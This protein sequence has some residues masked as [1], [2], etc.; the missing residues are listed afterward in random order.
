MLPVAGAPFVEHIVHFL[1]KQGI[2]RFVFLTGYLANTIEH[3]FTSSRFPGLDIDFV[4]EE[5]PLGT[6][7]AVVHAL[8]S[9]AISGLFFLLNGDSFTP[10]AYDRLIPPAGETSMLAVR[11]AEADRYGVLHVD[12]RGKLQALVEK[13][14]S[15]HSGWINGGIYCLNAALFAGMKPD[16]PCSIERECIQKWLASGIPINVITTEGPFLDI[17]TPESLA[18]ANDFVGYLRSI[19]ARF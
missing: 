5:T 3:H 8:S 2:R 4:R 1:A 15:A 11:M 17:G 6:G 9:R 19:E 10:F 14:S 16:S 7:G 13:G 12:T 18:K